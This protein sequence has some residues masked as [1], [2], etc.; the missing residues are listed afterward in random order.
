MRFVSVVWDSSGAF[1]ASAQ[2]DAHLNPDLNQWLAWGDGLTAG[3]GIQEATN[4]NRN[5]VLS[6]AFSAQWSQGEA[7]SKRPRPGAE[8]SLMLLS[9]VDDGSRTR[10]RWIHSPV[11]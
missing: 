10:N 2:A 1:S 11:L 4:T 5:P 6:A 3:C 7:K 8:T 9:G